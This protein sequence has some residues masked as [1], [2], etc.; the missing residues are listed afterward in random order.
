LDPDRERAGEKY[1]LIRAR[2]VRIFEWRGC[3]GPETLADETF[4]RVG[5]R[6]EQGEQIRA[7]DPVVYFYG[8]ARNVLKEYWTT[9]Q[10]EATA[11]V[12]GSVSHERPAPA[13][14]DEERDARLD[15]LDRCLGQMPRDSREL[16]E[17][18][19][20]SDAGEKIADRAS[21]AE[22]LGV[23][24]GTL[25]IRAHRIRRIL[26]ACVNECMRDRRAR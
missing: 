10:K 8:V 16:I 22:T 15:C 24:A 25:R 5:R 19:Y 1:E 9:Q 20:R 18:Y 17:R 26:E 4:D 14:E 12:S 21:L 13:S 3:H 11:R 7:A 23:S 2:L 6:L